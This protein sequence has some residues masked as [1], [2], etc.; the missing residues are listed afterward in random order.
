LSRLKQILQLRFKLASWWFLTA[1]RESFCYLLKLYAFAGR[2]W[3][4]LWLWLLLL[5]GYVPPKD[6]TYG[7]A[8]NSEQD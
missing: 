3:L 7:D 1:S 4:W 5:L 6:A 2:P 8:G